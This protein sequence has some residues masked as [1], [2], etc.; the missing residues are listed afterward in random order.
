MEQQYLSL[1]E[2]ILSKGT[3]EMG[4][5]GTTLSVFG[6][7]MKFSLQDGVLPVLTTKKVSWKNCLKELLWFIS[8]KTNN[9]ILNEQCVH[10]W[11]MNCT[12]EFLTSRG[13]DY[14]P[15]ELGPIYGF[16]WRHFNAPYPRNKSYV[17]SCLEGCLE[18]CL[19]V[20]PD[21]TQSGIDQ[22]QNIITMLKDPVQRFS[23]R[24]V[25]TAWN[26][27]QLDD[28]ALPPCHIFVQFNVRQGNLIE[29][30]K[31]ERDKLSCIM[32]QRSADV[33]LGMPYNITSYSIFTHLLAIHCDMEADEFIYMIGNAHIYEQHIEPLKHQ[34]RLIPKPF[35]RISIQ[36]KP[37]IDDYVFDDFNVYSYLSHPIISMK[38][39]P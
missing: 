16:Q 21:V 19:E 18:N 24:L 10:I 8:G 1:I 4:R 33:G 25:M 5:N 29:D 13:L 27:C 6:E 3:L 2:R 31:K 32:Y 15:G 28:M 26:P 7:T 12:Q 37:D 30:G 23:R 20:E 34:L 11:D 38:M 17:K 22:L 9:K 39:V 35:P 14:E 36:S